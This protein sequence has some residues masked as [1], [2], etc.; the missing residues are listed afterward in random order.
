VELTQ[1]SS[2]AAFAQAADDCFTVTFRSFS[3]TLLPSV[4]SHLQS[5]GWEAAVGVADQD[6]TYAELEFNCD[7]DAHD[8]WLVLTRVNRECP[9]DL[10][11][12]LTGIDELDDVSAES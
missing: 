12:C 11:R 1:P 3:R 8:R 7:G 6:P 10:R 4:L 5:N 2:I 9:P